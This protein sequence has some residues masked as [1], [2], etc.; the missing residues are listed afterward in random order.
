M[1]Q[2]NIWKLLKLFEASLIRASD[3]GHTKTV[4][5][6]IEQKNID[7]NAKDIYLFLLMLISIILD[8]K[9]RFGNYSNY[10]LHHLWKHLGMVT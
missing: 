6:L 9:I 10:Y 3:N 2:N 1:F 5:I 8:F 7:I 4:K